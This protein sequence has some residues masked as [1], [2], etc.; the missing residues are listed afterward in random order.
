MTDSNSLSERS[1]G[2]H[3]FVKQNGMLVRIR[4][5]EIRWIEAS[6]NCAFIHT[7]EKRY[8]LGETLKNILGKLEG[9]GLIRVHRS[10]AVNLNEITAVADGDLLIGKKRIP[11]GR[12]HRKELMEMITML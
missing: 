10:Y 5:A 12:T 4:P 9:S 6:D 1:G 7:L 2:E 11:I 3:L 8:I